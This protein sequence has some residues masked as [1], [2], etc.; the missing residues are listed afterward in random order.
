MRR[1]LVLSLFVAVVLFIGVASASDARQIA[2]GN[3][4]Y[5]DVNDIRTNHSYVIDYGSFVRF[6]LGN[7]AFGTPSGQWLHANAKVNENFHLGAMVNRQDGFAYLTPDT[8][9]TIAPIN[10]LDVYGAY[11]FGSYAA[12]VGLYMANNSEESSDNEKSIGVFGFTGGV[13]TGNIAASFSMKMNSYKDENT[14]IELDG[15]SEIHGEFWG[16]FPMNSKLEII[17]LVS[18]TTY[19]YSIDGVTDDGD[20]GYMNVSVG[21]GGIYTM[22]NGGFV[23]GGL[24]FDMVENMDESVANTKSTISSTT[25]PRFNLAAEIPIYEKNETFKVLGRM[26]MQK[27]FVSNKSEYES[28]SVDSESTWKSSES[29]SDFV[30]IG[31][32]VVIKNFEI[33]YTISESI[34]FEGSYLLSGISRPVANTISVTYNVTK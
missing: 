11:N 19:S 6:E 12:S 21:C 7:Y 8:R 30:S 2:L 14:D 3:A 10:G 26:G 24:S 28:G 5:S 1:V 25:F 23:S 17:P 9:F 33:D 27:S 34:L 32:G 15:G 4:F 16:S 18:F 20:M 31:C 13:Y 22:K 29:L